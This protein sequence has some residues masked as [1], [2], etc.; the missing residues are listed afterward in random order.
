MD[1]DIKVELLKLHQEIVEL[2]IEV[3][4]LKINNIRKERN[5]EN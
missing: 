1:N 3:N 5:N 2:K 4:K